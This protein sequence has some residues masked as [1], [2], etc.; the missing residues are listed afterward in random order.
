MILD[1]IAAAARIRAE[2]SK[3]RIPLSEVKKAAQSINSGMEFPFEKALQQPDISF[4][5]EIKKASPSRGIIA[6]DFPYLQIAREY[7]EAG[8]DAISV[9]T[10]P[11]YFMGSSEYLEQVKDVVSIPVLRKDFIVDAYQIY[12]TKNIGAAAI[13]LICAS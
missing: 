1:T 4:I 3:A 12:E 11:E 9:L 7:E 8:A 6:H 13:L 10:E 2:K 5:C